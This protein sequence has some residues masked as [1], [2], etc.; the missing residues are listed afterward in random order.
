MVMTEMERRAFI[1][2]AAY[3]GI[4]GA[5][6][7]G[8][9]G[10]FYG[11][12]ASEKGDGFAMPDFSAEPVDGKVIASVSGSER[13]AM[14]KTALDML[15]GIERFIAPGDVVA[16][17]PNVAFASPATLGATT[18]PEMVYEMAKLCFSAGAKEVLV[19]DNP[20]NSPASCF[21]ISGVT[22][23]AQKAGARVIVP[24]ESMFSEMS[25][26]GGSLIRNWPI[27]TSPLKR[28]DKLIGLAPVKDHHRSGAS[29]TMKNWYGLLGGRRNIFHQNING[30]INELAQFVKPTF[31]VLDGVTSMMRNG[32][33]GGSFSDLKDTNR[34]IVST[35][36]VAADTLGAALLEREAS[37]LAYIQMAQDNGV[38]INDFNKLGLLEGKV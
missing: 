35:D 19:F 33:T 10:F 2:Q 16:I 28:A 12:D 21:I 13:G 25:L 30:I 1:K 26:D 31:V 38:G 36:M 11:R 7:L 4:T 9:A 3:A 23:A 8:A 27:F 6:L 15:G 24:A 29:M 20:I 18:S 37:S 32:P 22:D 34:L 17:K 14:L 5:A